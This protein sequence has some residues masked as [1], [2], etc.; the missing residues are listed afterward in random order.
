MQLGR[1]IEHVY[2]QATPELGSGPALAAIRSPPNGEY[3][4][5]LGTHKHFFKVVGY[6]YFCRHLSFLKTTKWVDSMIGG[7]DYVR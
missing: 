7:R 4:H 1:I 2:L 5:C 3:W 6:G